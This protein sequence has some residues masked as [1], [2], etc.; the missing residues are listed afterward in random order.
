MRILTITYIAALLGLRA[1]NVKTSLLDAASGTPVF[2]PGNRYIDLD[3]D[4][5][6]NK[7]VPELEAGRLVRPSDVWPTANRGLGVQYARA[8]DGIA[9]FAVTLDDYSNPVGDPDYFTANNQT[10]LPLSFAL[11][12]KGDPVLLEA[13]DA[14]A[15][16][17]TIY[18]GEDGVG[19]TAPPATNPIV[20]G[21]ALE[22]V[23]A[24]QAGKLLPDV[25]AIDPNALAGTLSMRTIAAVD[26][27]D[28]AAIDIPAG[29]NLLQVF[30]GGNLQQLGTDYNI[31]AGQVVPIGAPWDSAAATPLVFNCAE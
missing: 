14:W 11:L 13:G 8:T 17:D 21:T 18:Q 28:L 25:Q 6:G 2:Y 10:K 5:S 26:W 9:A 27:D 31:V 1:A 7:V 19:V 24:G 29:C 22:A 16:N 30:L 23:P 15:R 4:G 12:G 20:I 3:D